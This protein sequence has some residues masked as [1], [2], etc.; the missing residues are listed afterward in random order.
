MVAYEEYLALSRSHDSNARGQAAQYAA[1]AFISHDGPPDEQAALYA[2]LIR[3]LDDSS[4]KVRAALAYGLLRSDKAPR[5]IILA[6]LKDAGVVARAVAQY[7]PVLLENDLL[8]VL[9]DADEGMIAA[10]SARTRLS[11]RVAKTIIGIAGL[12][13]LV[14]IL[15]R[16][17]VSF[18]ADF[19]LDL[20][21]AKGDHA[22]VRGA[23]LKRSDLDAAT[24]L[25]LIE[26]SKAALSQARIVKGAIQPRR[27]ARVLRDCV[28]DALSEIGERDLRQGR[29]EF[30]GDM[31]A[32]DRISTRVMLHALVSGN[33]LFFS[34]CLAKLADTPSQKVF[35]ILDRGS[36]A[37][38]NALLLR[39]GF[40]APVRNL[41]ARLIVLARS[42]NLADDFA[43]R[44][45]IVSAVIEEII[46][47]T[48]GEI[49]AAMCD[50]FDY[51]NEQNIKLARLA[52]RGVME[53]FAA[54]P[55]GGR[56]MP[57]AATEDDRLALPAA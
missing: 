8:S 54:G 17:D 22:S 15:L 31:I 3:F 50:A 29:A 56:Y 1:F 44:H 57:I 33:V 18:D 30:A 24:R 42:A 52:A 13:T 2:S 26:K 45:F 55:E 5:P 36:R 12:D 20:A 10:I 51:L 7:S 6:L 40:A 41:L 14:D 9:R 11:T 4:I 27:L 46:V 35:S 43:A 23:M 48:D 28:E 19:L 38:L 16:R 34:D 32:S 25:V 49:P 37:A 53:S 21:N 47:E 39:C